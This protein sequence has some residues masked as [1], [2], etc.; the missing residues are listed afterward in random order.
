M[1]AIS[2]KTPAVPK[3][4]KLMKKQEAKDD[5]IKNNDVKIKPSAKVA[6]IA[7][8]V[9]TGNLINHIK[10]TVPQRRESYLRQQAKAEFKD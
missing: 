10:K 9:A 1:N 3:M 4:V 2:R 8:A 6:T 5:Y 7:N